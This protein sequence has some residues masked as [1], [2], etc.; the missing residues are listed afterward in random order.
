MG[1]LTWKQ[2]HIYKNDEV[3]WR[4]TLSK[5]PGSWIAHNNLGRTLEKQGK[6]QEAFE[7]YIEAIALNPSIYEPHNNLGII[8][9]KKGELNL[10]IAEF[11]KSLEL[12]PAYFGTY[13]DLATALVK[14]GNLEEALHFAR[15]C[16]SMKPDHA[17]GVSTLGSI[18]EQLG[19]PKEAQAI[20]TRAITVKSNSAGK[21]PLPHYGLGVIHQRTGQNLKAIT[22]FKQAL[23]LNPKLKQAHYFLA[24][25]YDG[26]GQEQK[27]TFHIRSAEKV[28][29]KNQTSM[30]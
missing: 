11:K 15:K 9:Y 30:K 21:R 10:A 12:N 23:S 28:A 17:Q 5:N 29:E 8:Y 18:L 4:D 27:A 1:L 22:A 26:M 13:D 3:L 24:K 2:T 14:Q 25:I 16:V 6:L 19:K 20:Y 7:N